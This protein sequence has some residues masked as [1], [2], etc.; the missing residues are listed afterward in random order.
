VQD[1]KAAHKLLM[2]IPVDTASF[3]TFAATYVSRALAPDFTIDVKSLS[4]GLPRIQNR[5]TLAQNADLVVRLGY[6]NRDTYD[7][8][9]VSDFD[10]AGVEP[11][12]EIVDVPVIGGFEPQ[13]LAAIT[14]AQT[15][16]IITVSDALIALDMSHLRAFGIE[17]NLRSVRPIGLTVP[18][19]GNVPK[20]VELVTREALAAIKEDGAQAII[21]GCTGFLNVAEPVAKALAKVGPAVP[22]TDPNWTSIACLQGLVRCGLRQSRITYVKN[23]SL[24]S[25]VAATYRAKRKRG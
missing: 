16:S 6:E 4:G 13:A 25:E 7:G 14:L 18:E 17:E 24:T 9:F 23:A 2:I 21:L 12:R 22:V 10:R 11:L 19:L 15:F 20:V 8:I 3:N 5:W 1:P